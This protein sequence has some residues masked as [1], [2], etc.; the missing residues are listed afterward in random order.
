MKNIHIQRVF[1]HIKLSISLLREMTRLC[2]FISLIN[3]LQLVRPG[4][5]PHLQIALQNQIRIIFV[6]LMPLFF[7]Q[8][9]D[10]PVN[11]NPIRG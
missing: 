6:F 7:E 11:P 8:A 4:G 1:C 3:D 5:R 10:P 2:M 9:L